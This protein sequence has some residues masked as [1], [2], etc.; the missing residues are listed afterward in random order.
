MHVPRE[1]LHVFQRCV[2]QDAVADVEDVSWLSA[3]A[4]QDVI[5]RGKEAI[6]RREED[7]RIEVALHRAAVSDDSP[8]FIERLPPI[9]ANHVAAR[10]GEV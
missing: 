1:I 6:A 10:V 7:R 5:R 2:W 9:E 4:S 3:G 8:G